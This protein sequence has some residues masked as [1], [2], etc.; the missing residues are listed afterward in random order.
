M[1]ERELVALGDAV[2]QARAKLDEL[3]NPESIPAARKALARA[4]RAL[5]EATRTKDTKVQM[6]DLEI[7]QARIDE[8]RQQER[9]Q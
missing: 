5:K 8:L 6:T 2:T 3:V 7:L 4:V 1:D 9:T